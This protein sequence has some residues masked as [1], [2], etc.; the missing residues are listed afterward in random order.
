MSGQ[1]KVAGLERKLSLVVSLPYVESPSS[2]RQWGAAKG[3]SLEEG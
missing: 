1:G 3:L 2:P